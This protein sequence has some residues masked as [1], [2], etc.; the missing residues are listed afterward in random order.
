MFERILVPIDSSEPSK[1]AVELAADLAKEHGP[2]IIVFHA[3]P[4]VVSRYGASDVDEP[5]VARDVVDE[6][7]RD[8]KDRGLNARGE[9]V[10]VLEGHMARGIVEAATG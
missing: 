6:T 8:L 4:R 1:R 3:V 7:V 2:E 9:I 10:R 5:E